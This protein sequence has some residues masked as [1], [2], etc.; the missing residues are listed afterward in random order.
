MGIVCFLPT[1]KKD[2][3][4]VESLASNWV[5]GRRKRLID[6]VLC[7]GM[8]PAMVLPV[9]LSS[10]A[11]VAS[12]RE[13]PFFLQSR[14]GINDDLFTIVKLRTMPKGTPDTK[15]DG[16]HDQRATQIGRLLRSIWVDEGPQVYNVLKGDMSFVGPRPIIASHRDEILDGLHPRLQRRWLAA[17]SQCRPGLV[18]P[19]LVN[20]YNSHSS[21]I[22]DE[23]VESTIRYCEEGTLSEDV[24]AIRAAL[25]HCRNMIGSCRVDN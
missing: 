13:S 6:V 4:M 17:R 14:P 21:V 25:S 11:I 24:A 20:V 1:T 8:S 7:G 16:H 22:P 5:A 2:E 12:T 15:S 18:D 19:Y 9:G 23:W 10:L 3:S